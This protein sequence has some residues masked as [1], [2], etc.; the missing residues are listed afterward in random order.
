MPEAQPA[1]RRHLSPAFSAAL[2]RWWRPEARAIAWRVATGDRPDP[3]HVWLAEV[4]AQQTTVAA[5]GPRFLRFMARW[6]TL[7]A[8]AAADEAEVLRAWAGLGYYAR[9]RNLLRAARAAHAMGGLPSSEAALRSLPGVG[10]YTAA[11]I[12]AMAHG[13]PVLP[14]DAN[15]ARIGARLLA[16]DA[17]HAV[18]RAALEPLVPA[19]DPGGFAQALMDLG[20]TICRPRA[21]RCA[22]CPVRTWCAA[23]AAGTP[24]RW[25]TRP[26]DAARPLRRGMAWWIEH[27]AR[28]LLVRRPPRGLLGGMEALPSGPWRAGPQ[29]DPADGAPVAA[30]WQ[31][32][33]QPVVHVF[34]HFRLELAVAMA[35]LDTRPAL[36]GRWVPVADAAPGLPTLFARAVVAALAARGSAGAGPATDVA[37]AGAPLGAPG[38]PLDPAG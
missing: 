33:P 6:P 14:V 9:A 12:A 3:Y 28:V 11:A 5:A 27:D 29:P 20:A 25:P 10:A 17:S 19:S 34:T 2:M 22:A 35:R 30:A 21:P 24:E 37:A 18:V 32:L 7:A 16:R 1:A 31:V 23:L 4:M 15:V 36:P 38:S 13:A 8:L 26:L